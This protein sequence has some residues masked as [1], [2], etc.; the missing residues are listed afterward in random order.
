MPIELVFH[1]V[2][3]KREVPCFR[4]HLAGILPSDEPKHIVIF[5]AGF[6]MQALDVLPTFSRG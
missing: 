3:K 2:L 4:C 6:L 5:I 1:C